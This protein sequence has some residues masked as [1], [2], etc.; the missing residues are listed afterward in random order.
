MTPTARCCLLT[1]AAVLLAAPVLHSQEVGDAPAEAEAPADSTAKAGSEPAP[2]PDCAHDVDILWH[3]E[4]RDGPGTLGVS[5]R[6]AESKQQ[7][8][9]LGADAISLELDSETKL[10]GA[11][12]KITQARSALTRIPASDAALRAELGRDPVSY[13]AFFAVDLSRSMDVKFKQEDGSER[14]R[15]EQAVALIDRITQISATGS[16]AILG[17]SDRIYVSGFD[18]TVHKNLMPGLTSDRKAI[19]PALASLLEHSP[20]SESTAL[21]AAIDENLT[22]IER[23]APSN[24]DSEGRREAVLFVLTDSFNG[25]DLQ[26]KRN[27]R[28]CSQNEPL[29]EGLLERIRQVRSATGQRM[30][31][32]IVAFGVD[33]TARGYSASQA[34]TRRCQ[35]TTAQKTTVDLRNFRR[36]TDP[37]LGIGGAVASS[38]EAVLLR[39]VSDEFELRRTPYELSYSLPK[40]SSAP[41]EFEVAVTREGVT[42][43]DKLR[44]AGD[45]VPPISAGE[46]LSTSPA[47]MALFLASLLIAL[48]FVPRSLTNLAERLLGKKDDGR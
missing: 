18:D 3:E 45:I 41:T 46:D 43:S 47:E 39:F 48:L 44:R 19:R 10:T 29:V 30:R 28:R 2:V 14:T 25:R 32:Y 4:S 35:P 8:P 9:G 40:G 12:L 15:R 37:G 34:P 31:L 27:L 23:L 33:G 13:D 1:L 38:S 21:F 36:L 16:T 24:Q 20:R 22:I 6:D 26:A 5:I 11:A 42:C 17:A 7:I